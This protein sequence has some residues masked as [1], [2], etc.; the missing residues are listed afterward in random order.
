MFTERYEDKIIGSIGCFDRIVLI[1]TIPNICYAQGMTMY[2]STH[3]LKIF[4][5]PQ[6]VKSLTEEIVS[7]AKKIA[8]ENRV[9]VEFVRKIDSFRKE[10]RVKEIIEQRGEHPGLVHI[11]SAL[12]ACHTYKPWYDKQSHNAFFKTDCGKCLHYYFYFID[13]LLGLCYL[14]VSTWAPFQLQFYCNGHSILANQLKS[15][16][17]RFTK[18]ENAFVQIDDIVQ[19]QIFCTTLQVVKPDHVAIFLGRKLYG[20]YQDE[21]GTRLSTRIEGKCI[22]HYMGNTGIKMYDKFGSVLRIETTS[23]DVT[24]FNHYRKVEHR[25]GS[26]TYKQ[27]YVRKT[28]YSLPALVD[29]MAACNRR[30]LEFLSAIDDPSN[31]RQDLSKLSMRIDDGHRSFR[32]FNFFAQQDSLLFQTLCRGEFTIHGFSNRDL[33]HYL[34]KTVGQVSHILKNLR[35]HGII[36]KVTNSYRYYLTSMGKR[37]IAAASKLKETVVIP[38]LRTGLC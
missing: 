30:Y 23:N 13:E 36:K 28:L 3:Q 38:A 1:G 17:I 18:V 14:R 16:K 22:K 15:K 33:R 32:G 6:W 10:K 21:L 34:T 19:A 9:E 4:D 8:E 25:D 37:V 2:F 7:N 29:I 11:F 26:A 35:C 24:F 12:E 27:A 20:N 31:P 5:Y